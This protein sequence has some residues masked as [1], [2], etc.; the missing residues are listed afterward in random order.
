MRFAALTY[1]D[2]QAMLTQHHSR[3]L[4]IKQRTQTINS[5]RGRC[6]EF[7]V[8]APQNRTG[9][10]QLIELVQDPDDDR[11]PDL[12]RTA[13]AVQMGK[14]ETLQARIAELDRDSP[15]GRPALPKR[16]ADRR[17]AQVGPASA[18]NRRDH[19][20]SVRRLSAVIWG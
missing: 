1:L 3:R 11:L 2:V 20:L 9:V 17:F 18:R 13:L 16:A 6:A 14:L 15:G 7:G 4:L 12:A 8:V 19:A 5:L 10:A